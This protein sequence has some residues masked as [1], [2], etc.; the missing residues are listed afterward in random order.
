MSE[1][2]SG[3]ERNYNTHNKELLAIIRA[4]TYWHIYLKGT[5]IPITVC[6]VHKNLEYWQKAR[7]FN[8][9]HTQWHG[10][11]AAYNFV[12]HD[13]PGKQLDIPGAL[14]RQAGYTDALC[15]LDMAKYKLR[16]ANDRISV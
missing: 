10:L 9:R 14:S 15:K 5:E 6:L 8:R 4:L 7:D 12:I 13:R 3:P 1:S 16:M 11:L 2:L